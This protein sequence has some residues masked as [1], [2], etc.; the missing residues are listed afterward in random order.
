MGMTSEL[1]Q[2]TT[3]ILTRGALIAA[4]GLA[5]AACG[6]TAAPGSG[7]HASGSSSA[8]TT[9]A[10]KVSLTIVQSG[11][12]GSAAKHW[13]L[14][15]EPAGGT[16]PDPAAACGKLTKLRTI[17]SPSPHHVMCPMIM[18]DA[19]SYIVYGTF[20]GQKVHQSIVDGGCSLGRW[21]QLNQIFN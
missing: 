15:C 8:A 17:F 14:S 2:G 7:A 20:L 10:A 9:S 13:T 18:A 11:G 21:N 4:C 12:S 1:K 19:R 16:F 3:R 6:S 5:A